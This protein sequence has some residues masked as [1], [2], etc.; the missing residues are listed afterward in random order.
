MESSKEYFDEIA[1]DWDQLRTAFFSTSVREK[2][3][4]LANIEKGNVA[5][6]IGAGTGFVTEGLLDNG[7]C[8]IA[9][10]QSTQMLAFLEEKFKKSGS[11]QCLQADG[12]SLPMQDESV[13]YVF[14]NMFLHHVSNPLETIKEM[15]RVLKKNGKMVITDL[16][17]HTH[18]F[19][20]TEQ[21]DVWLGFKRDQIEE[22]Y[23]EAGFSQ[24]IIDCVG[25][26]CSADSQC[27]S[28][29]CAISIFAGLGIK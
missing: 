1:K 19:L 13:D 2:A 17:E 3:F 10:D 25:S 6:D 21:H 9:V 28:D 7:L 14:A 11:I 20:R 27:G 29:S 8:V 16:D 22:W 15:Y 4:E 26:N 18:E 12:N 23:K 5:A 24:V